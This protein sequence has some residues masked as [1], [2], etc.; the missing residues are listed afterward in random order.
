MAMRKPVIGTRSGA[1]PEVIEHGKTGLLA[2]PRSPASLAEALVRLARDPVL[3][4]TLGEAGAA[5]VATRFSAARLGS[6]FEA[7]YRRVADG[8]RRS[9]HLAGSMLRLAGSLWR[10]GVRDRGA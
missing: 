2:E 4:R 10:S 7:L 8:P 1:I 6:D 5:S 9:G 3:R